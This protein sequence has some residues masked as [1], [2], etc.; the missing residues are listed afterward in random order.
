MSTFLNPVF[1]WGIIGTGNMANKFAKSL[2]L[3]NSLNK[4][5]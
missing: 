5:T 3:L 1:R 4:E 2:L